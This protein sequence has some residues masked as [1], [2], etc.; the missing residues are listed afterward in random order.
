MPSLSPPQ[1]A[2]EL[3]RRRGA[4]ESIE[5]YIDYLQL[6]FVPATHHRLLIGELKAV[7]RGEC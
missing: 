2:Q 3:L 5:A 6:R 4:K 7:E 1:A